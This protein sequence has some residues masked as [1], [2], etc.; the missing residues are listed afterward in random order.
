MLVKRHGIGFTPCDL[1]QRNSSH[2]KAV[3]SLEAFHID[4]CV[5]NVNALKLNE[6][7][8][9]EPNYDSPNWT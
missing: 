1:K 2:F 5:E 8:L 7:G 4:G 9:S 3:V 6:K